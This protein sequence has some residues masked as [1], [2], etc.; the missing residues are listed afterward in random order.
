MHHQR[1]IFLKPWVVPAV[2]ISA[3]LALFAK[4]GDE[5]WEREVFAWDNRILNFLHTH[6]SPFF[7]QVMLGFTRVGGFYSMAIP[8]TAI[9][10]WLLLQRRYSQTLFWAVAVGGAVI[11]NPLLKVVFQRQRPDLWSSIAPEYDFSFPSGHSMG[12]AA[13]VLAVVVLLW[14]TRWRYWAVGFG[15]IFAVGV[16]LSRL[17]LGVHFPS[18]VLAAWAITVAWVGSVGLVLHQ[19]SYARAANS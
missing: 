5:I 6:S 13:F 19:I 7:D 16:A 14:P 15:T 1:S 9:F 2:V 3:A 12:S 10:L 4:L 11:L 17:Y 8:T 18:D